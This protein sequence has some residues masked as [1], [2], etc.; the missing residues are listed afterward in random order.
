MRYIL[1]TVILLIGG[2]V[3]TIPDLVVNVMPSCIFIEATDEYGDTWSGS[4]F[5]ID[6]NTIMTAAHV[7]EGAV[8]V[9]VVF[10]D[11]SSVTGGGIL[12]DFDN[13]IG[14]L[15]LDCE[16]QFPPVRFAKQ[17]AVLGEQVFMIGSPLGFNQFNT[18]S[19]GYVSGFDRTYDLWGDC[20]LHTGDITS[21]PGNSGSPLFNM[22]GKVVGIL[23]GGMVYSDSF[24][25]FVPVEIIR[26]AWF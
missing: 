18:L 4:G 21:Y 15:F 24:A 13:D 17:D 11:G 7:L 1:L 20:L 22:Q 14:F 9:N 25:I 10:V 19:V 12:L 2:C 8:D 26:G 5:I 16:I 3:K 6:S 23:V